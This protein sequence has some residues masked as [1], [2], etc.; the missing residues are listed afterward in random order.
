MAA[1]EFLDFMMNNLHKL[2]I[3]RGGCV[4]VYNSGSPLGPQGT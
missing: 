3:L 2:T 1:T 4:C